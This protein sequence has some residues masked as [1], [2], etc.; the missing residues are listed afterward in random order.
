MSSLV[1]GLWGPLSALNAAWVEHCRSSVPASSE[2]CHVGTLDSSM[3]A[4]SHSLT[5]LSTSDDDPMSALRA[6]FSAYPDRTILLVATPVTWPEHFWQRLQKALLGQPDAVCVSAMNALDAGFS[7]FDPEAE[8][9]CSPHSLDRLVFAHAAHQCPPIAQSA[10]ACSLWRPP[11]DT[12]RSLAGTHLNWSEFHKALMSEGLTCLLLTDLYA[13]SKSEPFRLPIPSNP[14]TPILA[15]EALRHSFIELT[16]D[17]G[18]TSAENIPV[19]GLDSKPVTLH[20]CHSWGGGTQRWIDD[21]AAEADERWHLQLVSVAAHDSPWT[22][23][24]FELRVVNRPDL[25]ILVRWQPAVPIQSVTESRVDYR[26]FVESIVARFQINDLIISS[27]IGHSLD[28][29]ELAVNTLLVCHDYYPFIPRLD[30]ALESMAPQDLNNDLY[31]DAAHADVIRQKLDNRSPRQWHLFRARFIKAL[32]AGHI[33]RVVPDV[34][35]SNHLSRLIPAVKTLDWQLIPHGSPSV[36]DHHQAPLALDESDRMRVLIPGR[37]SS[38]KGKHLL[39]PLI[40]RCAKFA[41]FYLLGSGIDGH[42]FFG[43]DHVHIVLDY[44]RES[45]N[46]HV[47]RIRPHTAVLMSTVSETFSY[48]LTEMRQLGVPIIA[49]ALGSFVSRIE[50]QSDGLLCDPTVDALATALKE[51]NQHR[52]TLFQWAQQGMKRSHIN[53]T[54]MADQYRR[55]LTHGSLPKLRY[56]IDNYEDV[57][58]AVASLAIEQLELISENRSLHETVKTQDSELLRRGDWAHSL[59]RQLSESNQ[60]SEQLNKDLD[61]I[62]GRYQALEQIRANTQQEL[63][64]ASTRIQQQ[65]QHIQQQ[66]QHIQSLEAD[67]EQ[68][69][70]RYLQLVQSLSWRLTKP[71]RYSKRLLAM[72][73]HRN[74]DRVKRLK[75]LIGRTWQSLRAHGLI[76]T[77]RRI[78]RTM[79]PSGQFKTSQASV[80]ISDPLEILHFEPCEQ[81]RVSIIIPVYN[82]FEYTHQCLK[83]IQSAHTSCLFEVIVVDDESSDQ[84]AEMLSQFSGITSL[85]NET[86]QGFI[87]TCNHGAEHA[88]GDYLFFLNN[89]TAVAD[90]FLDSLL[91]EFE[92]DTTVG[93]AGSKLVYPDGRLQE[94]GGIIFNDATGWNYGKFED[95][96]HPRYN[97][98]REVDYISGAAIMV[99]RILFEQIGGFDTRFVPAYYEDVDLAFEIRSRGFRVLYQPL[100]VV[101]HFEGITSGTDTSSGTK[102]YQLVNQGKFHD[103]WQQTLSRHPRSGSDLDVARAHRSSH[104]VLIIDATTPDAT[105]D[106]GS[107]RLINLFRLLLNQNCRVTFFADNRAWVDGS[108]DIL[109]QMGVEVWYSPFLKSPREFLQENG[110][111]FDTILISRHYIAEQY[112]Q[113]VRSLAPRAK[114]VFDTIDLHFLREQRQAELTHDD[115]L[116]QQSM[117]TQRRE[118]AVAQAADLTLVVSPYEKEVLERIAPQVNVDVLATIHDVHGCRVGYEDRRDIMF[119]GGYQHSPNVDAVVFFVKEVMPLILARLPEV[120]FHIIGSK[121]PPEITRLASDHV[122]YHGFVENLEPFLDDIRIAVAPLRFGAGIKGKI[123]TSMSYGQPVVSTSLGIEGMYAGDGNEVLIADTPE[124]FA[125][126]IV[127]LYGSEALWNTLSHNGLANV[128]RYFSFDA[129]QAAVNRILGVQNTD[130]PEGMDR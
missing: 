93:L 118:L 81:P 114:L 121:A 9:A 54:D 100:S 97:F 55:L 51:G 110:H 70:D 47:L 40:E 56:A 66:Q 108:S 11:S 32:S 53:L 99:P 37:L 74:A 76:D 45:L 98:V 91:S 120:R 63:E 6:L 7:P 87:K 123:N 85:R 46:D 103:K 124:S 128:E 52:Q 34:S 25:G 102:R 69:T 127:R 43:L 92:R 50:H 22:A 24:S 16:L 86:N 29:L 130:Q 101:T 3:P 122:V 119:V 77:L 72:L 67:V 59:D 14:A 21:L 58:Q 82:Q 71:L 104:D 116:L 39:K 111:R 17:E 31:D 113:M 19:P 15:V 28:V 4:Q 42:D 35:V 57:D 129:A 75:M 109:Q 83:S 8:M 90:D 84:T 18:L 62:H 64:D 44:P 106:A 13:G 27:L 12:V 79:T 41:D 60:W 105:Q 107:V 36:I 38:V 80:P 125:N 89:D 20:V 33:Q 30:I 1:V 94:A 88:R 126:A 23:E 65:Q 49:T 95:P 78:R 5:V 112:V 96:D 117:D 115:K 2:F 68:L 10:S 73:I 26:H 48:T 61:I